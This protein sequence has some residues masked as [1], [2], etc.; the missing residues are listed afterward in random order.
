[1]TPAAARTARRVADPSPDAAEAGPTRRVARGGHAE[2]L[3]PAGGRQVVAPG[4]RPVTKEQR[5]PL[6]VLPRGYR[7]PRAR[8]RRRRAMV[9]MS[10]LAAL[11]GVFG[12]VL[13][14]VELTAHQLGLVRL[15][16]QADA[17]QERYMKLR[18]EVAQL[19]SPERV[20]ARAQQLG[21]VPPVTI[22][23]VTASGDGGPAAGPAAPASNPPGLA[24]AQTKLDD[25]RR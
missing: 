11:A 5:P 1:M 6:T 2:R 21:M 12:L 15:Q 8:R 23:Y 25:S 10:V 16:K 20:V 22:T 7:S 9:G 3:A 14:H 13:V 17:Q 18:L 19:Q 24:W 4:A